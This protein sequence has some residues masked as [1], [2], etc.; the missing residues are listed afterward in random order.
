MA[1][2]STSYIKIK[3]IIV[4]LS[5]ALVGCD[6]QEEAVELPIR[7]VKH[8][9]ISYSTGEI[10]KT[11]SGVTKAELEADLSFRVSGRVE[12]IP[13]KVGDKL[14]KDQ[15]VAQLDSRD[16]IVLYEQAKAQLASAK[17]SLRSAE[18]E[19]DRTIGLYEK[20]NTSKSQ[21]DTARA[22]AESAQAQVKANIQQVETA[23]LQ[24][25]YTKLYAPQSCVISSIPVKENENV[26]S[27]QEVAKVNCGQKV[28]VEVDVPESY[29][30][31]VKEDQIV[32]VS[33]TALEMPAIT[34]RV[35]E[36]SSG[37]SDQTSAFPV[38]IVLDG[39]NQSIRAGL[40]AEVEFTQS[41]ENTERFF[42]LPINA[43]SH[44]DKG[45]FT[46]VLK[47]SENL[48]E[49]T[50][51]KQYITIEEIVQQGVRVTDGLNNGDEIVTAGITVIRDGMTVK[52]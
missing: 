50:V 22:A 38:T 7:S 40:A 21:L 27:G 48:D 25:S 30:D 46:Y 12:K 18:S 41:A 14:E 3:N 6:Q 15:L 51:H 45:D 36:I 1:R 44:D 10:V 35:T 31:E 32:S 49:A 13:V 47:V 4:I 33:L 20:R 28:E 19:Y 9:T 11:F 42:I 26:A 8:Q 16:Y 24:L 52:Y 34:G 29:I 23:R 5:L 17:A 37:S 2:T 39:N 43:V